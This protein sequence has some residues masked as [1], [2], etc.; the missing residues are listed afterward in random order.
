MIETIDQFRADYTYE[1]ILAFYYAWAKA[2]P[3]TKERTDAWNKYCDA[4]DGLRSGMSHSR[5]TFARI[6]AN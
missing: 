6:G 4:R 3:L 5:A 2:Q 1:Q